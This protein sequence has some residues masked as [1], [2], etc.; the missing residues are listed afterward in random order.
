VSHVDPHPAE[1]A[2]HAAHAPD[3]HAKVGMIVMWIIAITLVV[4]TVGVI[5]F[6]GVDAMPYDWIG[7][8]GAAIFTVAAI[9]MTR[10]ESH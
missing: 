7:V 4:C 9:A 10:I 2:E 5:L 1:P 3:P 6:K 8:I